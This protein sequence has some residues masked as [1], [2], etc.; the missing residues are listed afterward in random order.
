MKENN[1]LLKFVEL[2]LMFD[3]KYYFEINFYVK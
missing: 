2:N 3:I 1:F